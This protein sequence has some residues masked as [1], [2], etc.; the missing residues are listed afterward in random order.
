MVG[1]DIRLTELTILLYEIQEISYVAVPKCTREDI[2]FRLDG[3]TTE[4][5]AVES[6]LRE[7]FGY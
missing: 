7:S 4:L 2:L 3:V 1:L 5:E 6:L